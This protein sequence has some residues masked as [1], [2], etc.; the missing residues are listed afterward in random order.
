MLIHEYLEGV[1]LFCFSIGWYWSIAKMLR[2]RQA[3]GKSPC[4]VTLITIGYGLG[5]LSKGAYW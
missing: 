1:M 3:I 5:A 2:T 4:F